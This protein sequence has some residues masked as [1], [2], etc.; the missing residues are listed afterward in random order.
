MIDKTGLTVKEHIRRTVDNLVDIRG[1]N[2]AN[3]VIPVLQG[4]DLEDYKLCFEMYESR[5]IDL[6][7][8][9]TVGLG[10]VCRR[11]ATDEID[12]IV[13]YFHSKDLKL[14]GFGVKTQGFGKYAEYL[15]SADS[16]A[17]SFDARYGPHHCAKHK[18]NPT[19]KNCANCLDYALEWR[20][21]ALARCIA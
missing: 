17:W 4:W 14:H 9:H 19:T 20:E 5:G 18:E 10:S 21:R 16:M 3:H 2:P 15:E 1:K 11:Q 13:R 8:E 12:R 7:S 6:R